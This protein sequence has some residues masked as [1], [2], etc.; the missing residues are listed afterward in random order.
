MAGTVS[1]TATS[2][3]Y[4]GGSVRMRC[5]T[6]AITA[7]AADG[8]VPNTTIALTGE[9]VRLVTDP[10]ATAPTAGYDLRILDQDSQDVLGGEWEDRSATVTET[11]AP[12]YSVGVPIRLA[13]DHTLTMSG[14]AVNSALVTARIYYLG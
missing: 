14:N 8:S 6:L 9:I 4:Q 2:L 3:P 13:G 5:L 11:V 1:V 10:G 12:V 7:D